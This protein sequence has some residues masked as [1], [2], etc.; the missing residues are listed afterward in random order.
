MKKLLIFLML[1]GVASAQL[2]MGGGLSSGGNPAISTIS[3][4][5]LFSSANTVTATWNTSTPSDTQMNCG[6]VSGT[7]SIASPDNGWQKSVVTHLASCA[8]LNPSTTYFVQVTSTNVSGAVTGTGSM[9]TIALPSTT[10]IASLTVGSITTY[11]SINASNQGAADTFYNACLPTQCYFTNDDT[12]GF[13]ESGVPGAGTG[14]ISLGK[15]TSLSPLAIQTTNFFTGYGA[16]CIHTGDDGLSE[17]D[18]GLFAM[19]GTLFM[20]VG[21]QENSATTPAITTGLFSPQT[22]GQIISSTDGGVHWNNF[23]NP[24]GSNANGYV[25]TPASASMFGFTTPSNFAAATFAMDCADDGTL[26]TLSTC[27]QHDDSNVFVYLISNE[28]CWNGSGAASGCSSNYYLMRWP[29][30]KL[31]NLSPSDAQ[32]WLGG[33]GNVSTNWGACTSA[34]PII[35]E[36][37]HLGLPSVQWLPA[38]NRYLLTTFYYPSG[39]PP[40]TPTTTQSSVW[41]GYESPY[42]WGP[43]TKIYT[44]ATL[45][46]YYNPVI[47][48]PTAYS[49]TSLTIMATGNYQGGGS[50]TY[51]LYLF[52]VTVN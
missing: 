2:I 32:C 47:L 22:A 10:A 46:G 19:N 35:T 11:N 43:W 45:P 17:K 37:G 1:T 21:R 5:T 13:S 49:G 41:G 28:G 44:S 16:C 7:Y 4:L 25:T 52:P 38:K 20:A 39:N 26:G 6:T 51:Q 23:Q 3:N 33:D 18:N 42:P 12:T 15:F 14:A 9:A 29:R 48:N 8:N 27:N 50:T 34:S 30:T 24:G 40:N 31:A 36:A